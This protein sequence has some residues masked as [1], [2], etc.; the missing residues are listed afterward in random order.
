MPLQGKNLRSL[1]NPEERLLHLNNGLNSG[2][3]NFLLGREIAFQWMRMKNRSLG[4][5]PQRVM[6]FEENLNNLKASYFSAALMMPKKNL[7]ADFKAFGKHKKWDPELFLGLMTKYHVTPEM[8]MQRLT[9]ILP[10]VFGVENLFF[11]RFVAHSADKFTLTKELHLSERNDPHHAN[12]LNEHY[13]RRWISLE[14][15]QELYQQVKA[16]PDKQFIAGIQRSR[17]FESESEYLCLSIAFPNVSNREEAISVTVGF[18]IDDRLGDHLKFLDDPDIPA[19][20]VNTTCER[21]PISDCKERAYDAVIHKQSQH[22]EA[23]KNDIVD[24]LGTQRG[25]A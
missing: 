13:C 16:N 10:T 7:S 15:L 11:L 25:V 24:L 6:D 4:T 8:L 1:Y 9:N 5:P 17:Y 22:E 20:L 19:K 3:I 14:I 18:L 23:I 21:C 12:E 2:Q